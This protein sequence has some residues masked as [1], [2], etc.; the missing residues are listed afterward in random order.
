VTDA[1][2]IM[3]REIDRYRASLEPGR[4]AS[5]L[6]L[7]LRASRW[8]KRPP[9]SADDLAWLATFIERRPAADSFAA[10][11]RTE[12]VLMRADTSAASAKAAARSLAE[13]EAAAAKT[14]SGDRLEFDTILVVT[15]PL[16]RAVRGDEDARKRFRETDR[17]RFG[18]RASAA[19]DAGLAM[20]A[21][22]DLAGAEEAYKLAGDPLMTEADT[23][24]AVA[25][26]IKRAALYRSQKR[27]AEAD[28]LVVN[29][30]RLWTKADPD[31]RAAL[32]RLR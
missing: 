16:V 8:L 3:A 7:R 9:P 18:R 31:V 28:A 30:D 2:G 1:E 25:A 29:I 4:A 22:G 15:V 24:S 14:A 13:I 32:E 11:V 6:L 26:R 17:A 20:E 19:L 21:L 5:I 10:A 12:L 27:I 23:L